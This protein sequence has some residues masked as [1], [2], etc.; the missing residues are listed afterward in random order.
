LAGFVLL[1]DIGVPGGA[2]S[3]A[4]AC[5]M[6]SG[7]SS[8]WQITSRLS[9]FLEV[10]VAEAKAPVGLESAYY[11]SI[12]WSFGGEM[13]KGDQIVERIPPKYSLG[14]IK[15]ADL[16]RFIAIPDPKYGF[17]AFGPKETDVAAPKKLIDIEDRR[18]FA[19]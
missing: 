19:C 7:M 4:E 18:I 14:W 3:A 12:I 8:E 13:R 17:I 1:A 2:A 9:Q 10:I 11:P 5:Q 15:K 6:E 16:S